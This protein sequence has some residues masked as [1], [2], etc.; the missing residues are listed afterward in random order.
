MTGLNE[1]IRGL[2]NVIREW[3]TVQRAVLQE[4]A[5]FLVNEAKTKVHVVSGDLK[6][7]ISIEPSAPNADSVIVSA[8]MPYARIENDRRG[9]KEP[10]KHT[11][12][13]YGPHGYFTLAVKATEKDFA[14]RIKVNFDKLW[15]KNKSGG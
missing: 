15:A 3:P 1:A 14:S 7:S 11:K 4:A 2:D 6:N 8:K 13:P 5:R 12:P 9:N 10:G